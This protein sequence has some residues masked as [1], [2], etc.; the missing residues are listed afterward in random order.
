[1]AVERSVE[2]ALRRHLRSQGAV[3][4]DD[5]SCRSD[6]PVV[7]QRKRS[8]DWIEVGSTTTDS[9]GT[10]AVKLTDRVGHYRA[11]T[12]EVSSSEWTCLAATSP[13]VRHRH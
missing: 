1:V 2:L 3:A 13:T 9:D 12:P 4:S 6:V 10:F 5:A 7:I 8:A 11:I